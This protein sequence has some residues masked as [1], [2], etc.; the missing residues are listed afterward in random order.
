M[1]SLSEV[2]SNADSKVKLTLNDRVLWAKFCSFTNEMIVTKSG[3][4]MFPVLKLSASG[5]DPNCMYSILLDFSSADSHRWKYVNGEWIPGGKPEPHVP[6]CV[7]VHPDSP[8]FGSHW[9]KQP[10]SF[11]KVKL[12]NKGTGGGQQIMLNSLHKYEPRIHVVRV[13]GEAGAQRTIATFSF[14]ETK[15]IAVT[16][17]QNEEVTSLKIKHNPFAKAFLDAKERPEQSTDFSNYSGVNPPINSWQSQSMTALPYTNVYPPTTNMNPVSGDAYVYRGAIRTSYRQNRSAPYSINSTSKSTQNGAVTEATN[18]YPTTVFPQSFAY[19]EYPVHSYPATSVFTTDSS[20]KTPYYTASS[21]VNTTNPP[22][23]ASYAENYNIYSTCASQ[24]LNYQQNT[25]HA[26]ASYA[27][28]SGAESS[29]GIEHT[30]VYP[31]S[32]Y[33]PET[34]NLDHGKV[35]T[36]TMQY[37][38][39]NNLSYSSIWPVY[40]CTSSG[41]NFNSTY[42]AAPTSLAQTSPDY[43]ILTNGDPVA[44][45]SSVVT[46]EHY[47]QMSATLIPESY[48]EISEPFSTSSLLELADCTTPTEV[49]TMNL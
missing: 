24:E 46:D 23:Q 2:N 34:E 29:S 49:T 18:H 30:L 19:E 10:I 31:Y 26:T 37:Y 9:M 40:T 39:D 3:R 7:Y 48:T 21:E 27:G 4:R 13:G 15:F 20:P 5:L 16:A 44:P 14:P 45:L 12:T 38:P 6:S 41:T 36:T 28:Y 42:T 25:Y 32:G 22:L 1:T 11:N 33:S 43:H 17:Y 47:D 35:P 8:N